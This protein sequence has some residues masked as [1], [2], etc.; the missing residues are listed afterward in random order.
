M[1]RRFIIMLLALA[2]ATTLADSALPF[3][4]HLAGDTELPPPWG[5]GFDFY[6]MDQDYRIKTLDFQFPGL[7]IPD[8][9]V[10]AVTNEIQHLDIKADAWLFP[11][12]NVYAILG[13]VQSDTVV[14]LS[15]VP[16]AG[17]PIPLG[18]LPVDT[19]GTVWGVGFTLAVGG[20]RW[21]SSLSTTWTDTDLG[22]DFDSSAESLAVQPRFGFIRDAWTAWVGGMYLDTE[23][24][25]SGAVVI[26]GLG[27]IP[28]DV[29]LETSDEWNTT[30][31][32]NYAFSRRASISFEYGF[33][34]R[35]HTLLNWNYRY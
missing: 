16:Q 24:T 30:S 13:Q 29:V 12:L 20:E 1:L 6:T 2:P 17:L 21:F 4:K 26:P 11:F 3:M 33:G 15:G 14:D 28:F 19:D 7:I 10:L 8:T 23:E 25:H 9:S 5:I 34:D 22:G 35:S 31:G 32:V 27:A 18:K